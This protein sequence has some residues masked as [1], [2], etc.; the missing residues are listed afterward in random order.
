[1][2]RKEQEE[3]EVAMKSYNKEASNSSFIR[4]STPPISHSSPAP[5]EDGA[6]GSSYPSI[7]SRQQATDMTLTSS[8]QGSSIIDED[9]DLMEND[10][11]ARQY[12]SSHQELDAET[13][14]DSSEYQTYK[15]RSSRNHAQSSDPV[16]T[17]E[18]T[19]ASNTH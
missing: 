15:S 14:E 2:Y 12:Q 1:M 19:L 13:D 11:Q 6:A 16:P 7:T 9:E 18:M 8:Q 10:P 4:E 5:T 17:N 3:Y